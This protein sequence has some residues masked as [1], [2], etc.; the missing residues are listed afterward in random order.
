MLAPQLGAPRI[1]QREARMKTQAKIHATIIGITPTTKICT[2]R[3]FPSGHASNLVVRSRAQASLAAY[4]LAA[5]W[6][7]WLSETERVLVFHGRCERGFIG[8]CF[9]VSANYWQLALEP[10]PLIEPLALIKPRALIK[11]SNL[12]EPSGLIEAERLIEPCDAPLAPS[13]SGPKPRLL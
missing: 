9:R 6:W 4:G 13:W 8:S 7:T 1:T 2:K 11:P 10:A 3:C 5:A 12:I